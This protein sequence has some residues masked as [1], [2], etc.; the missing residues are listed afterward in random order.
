MPN[1][2]M[3]CPGIILLTLPVTAFMSVK[4]FRDSDDR[5][6]AAAAVTFSVI[7]VIALIFVFVSEWMGLF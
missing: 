5:R 3:L 4:A 2:R 1:M 6:S 7:Q